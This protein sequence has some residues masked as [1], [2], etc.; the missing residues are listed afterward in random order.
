MFH[1]KSST[2]LICSHPGVAEREQP[3]AVCTAPE[4]FI[5]LRLI[6]QPGKMVLV[7]SQPKIILGRHSLADVRL[8]LPYVSR[9]HC[10]F[11]YS[12]GKWMVSDLGS[13][14]GIVVNQEKVTA[15]ELAH[16]DTMEIGGLSFRIDSENEE[17]LP[18]DP[19]M[20]IFQ[21][22]D[23]KPPLSSTGLTGQFRA[24]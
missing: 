4:D 11:E 20:L 21:I 22:K 12:L 15:A 19:E 8:M 9:R 18:D 14:N 2:Y 5:P 3:A 17:I 10:L 16:G 7:L 6:Q 23:V 13:L 24:A 1:M